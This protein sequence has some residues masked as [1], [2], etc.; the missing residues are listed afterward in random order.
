MVIPAF[1]VGRTQAILHYLSELK[2][3][4]AIPDMPIYLDSPMAIDATEILHK[5]LEDLRLTKKQ[6]D[7]L[8]ALAICTR[9]PEDSMEI[10]R[11]KQPKDYYFCQ[12]HGNWRSCIISFKYLCP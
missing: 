10:D 9:L 7:E 3:E 4:Q 8:C 12:R 1:A 6:C 5:H 2:K 11:D